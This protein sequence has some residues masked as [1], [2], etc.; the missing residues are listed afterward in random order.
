MVGSVKIV[1]DNQNGEQIYYR[2]CQEGLNLETI[3]TQTEKESNNLLPILLN[4][5]NYR[6]TLPHC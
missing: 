4:T 1:H 6:D 2:S 3:E 5:K